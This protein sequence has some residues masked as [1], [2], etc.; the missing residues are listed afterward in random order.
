MEAPDFQSGEMGVQAHVNGIVM[1]GALA[2]VAPQLS[3][4][5]RALTTQVS[6]HEFTI[7][8]NSFCLK[9]HGSS[10]AVKTSNKIGLQRVCENLEF[11]VG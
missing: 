8:E 9:W 1:S 6:G 4:T 3:Y 2:L 11:A 10:H 5:Q 7:F